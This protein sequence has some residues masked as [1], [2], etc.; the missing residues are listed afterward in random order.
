MA[1]TG[2]DNQGHAFSPEEIQEL[3]DIMT[4]ALEGLELCINAR[5]SQCPSVEACDGDFAEEGEHKC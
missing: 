5:A 4:Q 3:L 1:S 2:D